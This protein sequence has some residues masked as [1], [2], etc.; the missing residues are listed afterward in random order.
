MTYC[1]LKQREVWYGGYCNEKCQDIKWP[2]GEKQFY[3]SDCIYM[4]E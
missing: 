2:K 1:E 4:R 3:T